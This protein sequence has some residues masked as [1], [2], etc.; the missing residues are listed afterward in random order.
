MPSK[1]H[2]DPG[3]HGVTGR[4]LSSPPLGENEVPTL[5]PSLGPLAGWP[6]SPC[7]RLH[8][9]VPTSLR[10]YGEAVSMGRLCPRGGCVHGEAVSTAVQGHPRHILPTA[11]L[12]PLRSEGARVASLVPLPPSHLPVESQTAAGG[13]HL[14]KLFP[15]PPG[16]GRRG[17]IAGSVPPRAA[18]CFNP[19]SRPFPEAPLDG[20]T[21]PT[22]PGSFCVLP[23]RCRRASN[24]FPGPGPRRGRSTVP[25]PAGPPAGQAA[26]QGPSPSCSSFLSVASNPG[27][28]SLGERGLVWGLVL[29]RD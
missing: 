11:L 16:R 13:L 7:L 22:E 8:G 18:F 25:K 28:G 6:S 24:A 10:C 2:S 4:L 15:A 20:L 26:A 12:R 17:V 1:N 9:P 5:P 23:P 19:Q 27:V 14:W 29:G 3:L 21:S